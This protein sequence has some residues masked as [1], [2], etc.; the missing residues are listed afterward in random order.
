M[1]T[2]KLGTKVKVKLAGGQYHI[3]EYLG[4]D[5]VFVDTH[6]VGVLETS[7]NPNLKPKAGKKFISTFHARA[8]KIEIIG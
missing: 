8:S 7:V 5:K 1:K 6:Y 4:S 2:I 3:G